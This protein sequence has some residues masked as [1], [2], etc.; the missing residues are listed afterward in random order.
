MFGTFVLNVS[1]S[2][3]GILFLKGNLKIICKYLKE[4][5]IIVTLTH[6]DYGHPEKR[7]D[8]VLKKYVVCSIYFKA[9]QAFDD[10]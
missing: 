9:S 5:S 2:I 6:N 1:L 3:T 10:V 8:C 4:W 7:T